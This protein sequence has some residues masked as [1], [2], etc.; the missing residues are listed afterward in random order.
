M[1][2]NSVF[3]E[4]LYN[5]LA[6]FYSTFVVILAGIGSWRLY[7]KQCCFC[8]FVALKPKKKKDAVTNL[9]SFSAKSI[10]TRILPTLVSYYLH[11]IW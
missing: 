8:V 10:K 6:A 4:L 2:T 7:Y 11:I 3:T 9:P 1:S 5:T